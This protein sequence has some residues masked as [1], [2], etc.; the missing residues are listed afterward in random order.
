[1]IISTLMEIIES[2]DKLSGDFSYSL[3]TLLQLC[4][5]VLCSKEQQQQQL[6][7]YDEVTYLS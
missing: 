4:C 5:S 7:T 2:I 6:L 1:M 3:S